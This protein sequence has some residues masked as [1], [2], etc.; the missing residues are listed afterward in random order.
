MAQKK[1][2]YRVIMRFG[3]ISE[4]EG[5]IK[6]FPQCPG[7]QFAFEKVLSFGVTVTHVRSGLRACT[8]KTMKLA[9][10]EL[11]KILSN[12]KMIEHI[13]TVEDLDTRCQKEKSKLDKL[14]QLK[15]EF[16]Q[17]TNI[18]VPL[19]PFVGSIDIIKLDEK[20]NP[21]DGTSLSDFILKKWGKRAN[22]IIDEMIEIQV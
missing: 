18:S 4:R 9:K 20:I 8:G 19:D 22:D 13:K 3:E 6:E 11:L 21:P 12:A 17:I 5:V 16:T 1:E 7:E 14:H 2:K 10:A 15:N